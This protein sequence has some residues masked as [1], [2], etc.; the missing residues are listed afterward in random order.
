MIAVC[1]AISRMKSEQMASAMVDVSGP[2]TEV[3][4]CRLFLNKEKQ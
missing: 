2:K 4:S 3:F 1:R